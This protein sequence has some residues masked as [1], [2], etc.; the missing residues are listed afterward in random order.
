MRMREHAVH[1]D[2]AR[3]CGW[4]SHCQKLMRI[5]VHLMPN[6]KWH[7]QSWCMVDWVFKRAWELTEYLI[8]CIIEYVWLESF[9]LKH[10]T[11]SRESWERG[12]PDYNGAASF[13]NILKKV[14]LF[15]FTNLC[16][17]QF[18]FNLNSIKLWF[19]VSLMFCPSDQQDHEQVIA[20]PLSVLFFF[21]SLVTM[22]QTSYTR[23]NMDVLKKI[24]PF[25]PSIV[26]F[27]A[28]V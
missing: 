11:D 22:S 23:R 9:K 12:Q 21:F 16:L 13:D 8:W 26:W 2:Y 19:V 15:I 7:F 28:V 5:D 24:T 10:L 6:N 3:I 25:V 4:K 1:A 17:Q 20:G 18:A 27:F 14:Q